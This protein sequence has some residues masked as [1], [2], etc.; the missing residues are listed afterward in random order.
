MKIA[1]V[2]N[3][4]KRV[5]RHYGMARQFVVLTVENGAVTARETR[6][7]RVRGSSNREPGSGEQ[8]GHGRRAAQLVADCQ[9]VVAGGMG[10]SARAN[11]ERMG[12]QAIATDERSVDEAA[13][14]C[15]RGELP[16]LDDLVHDVDHDHASEA[17]VESHSPGEAGNGA[18][19]ADDVAPPPP[20]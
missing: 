7:K 18:A 13:L 9:V 4:G 11:L 14:R 16:H 10:A 2:S 6:E 8:R 20:T 19:G 5:S 3:N 1:V 15:A 17:P 12:L